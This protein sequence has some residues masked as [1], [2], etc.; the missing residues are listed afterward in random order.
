MNKSNDKSDSQIGKF[1]PGE[2]LVRLA[3]DKKSESQV[4]NKNKIIDI[5]KSGP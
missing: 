1:K 4:T 3:R 2:P 5:K